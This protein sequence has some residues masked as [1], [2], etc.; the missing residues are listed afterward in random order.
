MIPLSDNNLIRCTN[1]YGPT[2]GAYDIK[3][4]NN[5]NTSNSSYCNFP[6]AYNIQGPNVYVN[7]QPSYTAFC[8]FPN[9]YNF[10]VL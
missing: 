3:I 9:G 4:C 8:G 6:L 1:S 5:S 7:G 2:F 10:R